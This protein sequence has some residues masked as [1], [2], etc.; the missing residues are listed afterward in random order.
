MAVSYPSMLP[1]LKAACARIETPDSLG[2]GY[3]LAPDWVA[4][5]AHVVRSVALQTPVRVIFP[6]AVVEATLVQIDEAA[7]CAVLRLPAPLANVAPLPI[8]QKCVVDAEWESYGFPLVSGSGGLRLT[9]T[10]QDPTDKDP[11]G[12]LSVVLHASE[13]GDGQGGPLAGFSGSPVVVRGQLIGHLRR[14]IPAPENPRDRVTRAELGI[15]YACPLSYVEALLPG[16]LPRPRKRLQEAGSAFDSEWYVPRAREEAKLLR[17][18]LSPGV[19]AAL[20][21]PER[22]GKTWLLKRLL[23]RIRQGD[24]ELGAVRVVELNLGNFDQQARSGLDPFLRVLASRLLLD[25]EMPVQLVEEEWQKGGGPMLAFGYLMRRVLKNVAGMLIL[26]IDRADAIIGTPFGDD[27]FGLFRSWADD[28]GSQ[29]WSKLRI[30]LCICS[31]PSSLTQ[32][33][34]QSP[35]YGADPVLLGDFDL[36]QTNALAELYGLSVTEAEHSRARALCGGHPFLLRRLFDEQASRGC[37]LNE[38]LDAE[39][40]PA[41]LF[42]EHLHRL[43]LWLQKYPELRAALSGL[44]RAQDEQGA[45]DSELAHRLHRA[46][47]VVQVKNQKNVYRLRCALY[48]QL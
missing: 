10:I 46:G 6:S 30:L 42:A 45:L 47:L 32:R 18:L 17:Q 15:V 3:L 11:Y 7:D 9:G 31:T 43:R 13:A 27:V 16:G 36:S 8:A 19:P 24:T 25:C 5:C 1:R 23:Q 20:W 37:T 26:A 34:N 2:T 38:L 21:G 41:E 4:T 29:P 28:A 35:L 22:F 14:I 48:K 44:M 39:G 40:D 33:P 12:A